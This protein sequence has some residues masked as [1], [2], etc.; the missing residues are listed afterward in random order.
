MKLPSS[1]CATKSV[2]QLEAE[3]YAAKRLVHE[4]WYKTLSPLQHTH[5]KWDK[6]YEAAKTYTHLIEM[7]SAAYDRW[8]A[9]RLAE[10]GTK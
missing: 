10:K 4:F 6:F 8:Q 1:V 3:H 7:A 9:A 2:P 5:D